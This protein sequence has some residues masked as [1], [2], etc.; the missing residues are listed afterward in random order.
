VPYEHDV[1]APL[2]LEK[3]KSTKSIRDP[4]LVSSN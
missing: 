4:N 1:E 2:P 3:K